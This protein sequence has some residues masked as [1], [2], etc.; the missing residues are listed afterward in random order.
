MVARVAVAV[1]P[2]VAVVVAPLALL[3]AVVVVVAPRVAGAVVAPLALMAV[4]VAPRVLLRAVVSIRSILPALVYLP[5]AGS[6]MLESV[7]PIR[8]QIKALESTY[9][10]FVARFHQLGVLHR[11]H[12]LAGC[13]VCVSGSRC[14]WKL[15][16]LRLPCYR[17]RML[18]N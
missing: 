12:N 8:I 15:Q 11:A 10:L 6:K 5:G 14:Y 3:V 2:L 16:L 17:S 7:F 13:S 18:S 1:A 4:A 9:A